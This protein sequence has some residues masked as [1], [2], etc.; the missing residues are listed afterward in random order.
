ML[1][2]KF[3]G[4]STYTKV[5]FSNVSEHVVQ[6]IG[7]K[8]GLNKETGFKIYKMDN[9]E[10]GD[11]SDYITIYR[12]LDDG[13]QY[14]NDGSHY[15]P[16]VPPPPPEPTIDDY[17]REKEAELTSAYNT[18]K[19]EFIFEGKTY[20][21]DP[22][23]KQMAEMANQTGITVSYQGKPA[24]PEYLGSL[25]V[26]QVKNG[27]D[28]DWLYNKRMKELAAATTITAIKKIKYKITDEEAQQRDKDNAEKVEFWQAYVDQLA[29]ATKEKEKEVFSTVDIL[30]NEVI[31]GIIDSLLTLEEDLPEDE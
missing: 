30:A 17:R 22:E 23:L 3:L 18:A 11:Y 16:P 7:D 21:V 9:L 4:D 28:Q 24:T 13:F 27:Y 29:F 1:K 5:A 31:P 19:A 2:V 26:A 14:S 15:D 8:K 10:L 6:L 12:E 25:L 20:T